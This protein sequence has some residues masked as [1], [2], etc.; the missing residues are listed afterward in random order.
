MMDDLS[1]LDRNIIMPRCAVNL[2]DRPVMSRLPAPKPE[3]VHCGDPSAFQIL[4]GM[5]RDLPAPEARTE[6]Q[7][8]AAH[9]LYSAA[10]HLMTRQVVSTKGDEQ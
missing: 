6:D 2:P 8:A 7:L 4:W 1:R 5:Y 9:T 3:M 10:V